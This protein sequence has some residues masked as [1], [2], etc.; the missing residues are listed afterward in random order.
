[1]ALTGPNEKLSQALSDAL[2]SAWNRGGV[3]SL[4]GPRAWGLGRFGG[5]CPDGL[6]VPF[7]GDEPYLLLVRA[8]GTLTLEG[9]RAVWL[10]GD[11]VDAPSLADVER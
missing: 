10:T 2:R 9:I 4:E 8:A 11:A 5:R 7:F 1:M 3:D 6:S